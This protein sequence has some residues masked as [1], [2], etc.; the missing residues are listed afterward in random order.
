[1]K[2]HF[3]FV[4]FSFVYGTIYGQAGASPAKQVDSGAP[5]GANSVRKP[6]APAVLEVTGIQFNDSSGNKNNCLDAGENAEIGFRIKNK[7]KGTAYGLVANIKTSALPGLNI[8]K[9]KMLGDLPAGQDLYVGIPLSG[10]IELMAGHPQVDI[11]VNEL[12]HFDADPVIVTF[13]T[14]S[15]KKPVLRIADHQFATGQGSR[16]K[17]GETAILNVLIQNSGQGDARDVTVTFYLPDNVYPANENTYKI[18]LMRPNQTYKIVYEFFANRK[19]IHNNIPVKISVTEEYNRFGISDLL[20]ASLEEN[21]PNVLSFNAQ[22][23]PESTVSLSN[24]ALRADVDRDIPSAKTRNENAYALIIGNE[25]YS[26]YQSGIGS[27]S[28][29]DFALND[30]SVFGTYCERTLGIPSENIVFR[31][32][33]TT[34]QM[35]QAIDKINKLVKASAGEAEIIVFFAGHGLPDETT[36]EAHLMPVDVTG[37]NLGAAIK[38]AY[39]YR[40]LTEYPSKKV[41]VFLDACFS[42]GSRGQGL[43]AARGVKVKP[44]NSYLSGNIVV[45]S[46][47]S[48]EQASLPWK[49]K[50]HGMFTYYLLKLLQDSKG[51]IRLDQLA[52][53]LK[54]KVALESVRVNSREQNPD[55]LFSETVKDIW[56]TWKLK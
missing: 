25:D 31:Q 13:S 12:N 39:L 18:G 36:K 42:G 44:E 27:E 46:A 33:A 56:N 55:V 23:L 48:G 41:C 4:I 5:P 24:A 53:G 49:E 28:N 9:Q 10:G 32:N 54:A 22:A 40:K 38:L 14:S 29:V 47:S 50:Q 43:V 3:L 37:A 45:F 16:I 17:R 8:Q 1:M 34:G 35:L 52:A 51:E 2:A 19:Y 26:S 7:G 11:L 30:A 21:L 15:Y 20:N 6:A